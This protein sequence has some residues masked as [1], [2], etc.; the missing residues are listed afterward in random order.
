MSAAGKRTINSIK[1]AQRSGIHLPMPPIGCQSSERCKRGAKMA[2]GNNMNVPDQVAGYKRVGHEPL[3]IGGMGVVWL[4]KEIGLPS[5][6]VAIKFINAAKMQMNK[7]NL[8]REI[9]ILSALPPHQNV[10]AMHAVIEEPFALVMEYVPGNTNLRRIIKG[11]P[12][13]LPIGL[14]AQI[15]EGALEGV[16]HAHEHH[17]LHRDIKPENILIRLTDGQQQITHRCI[18]IVDFGIS[19]IYREGMGASAIDKESGRPLMT[20]MGAYTEAYAA[21]EQINGEPTGAYTDIYQIG[22][23]LHEMLSGSKPFSG[24]TSDII[25]GHCYGQPA[26]IE[27]WDLPRALKAILATAMS[28]NPKERFQNAEEMLRALNDVNDRGDLVDMGQAP[29]AFD[30]GKAYTEE[31]VTIRAG[32]KQKHRPGQGGSIVPNEHIATE[33]GSQGA[34]RPYRPINAV[35]GNKK[36]GLKYAIFAISGMAV[37]AAA[38]PLSNRLFGASKKGKA[39]PAPIN[40]AALGVRGQSDYLGAYTDTL[41]K[42]TSNLSTSSNSGTT[43]LRASQ[44][45]PIASSASEPQKPST[46][47][48]PASR[49]NPA[50]T[51]GIGEAIGGLAGAALH[52]VSAAKDKQDLGSI[53]DKGLGLLGISNQEQITYTPPQP[54]WPKAAPLGPNQPR[55]VV[56]VQVDVGPNGLPSNPKVLGSPPSA[57]YTPAIEYAMKHTFRPRSDSKTNKHTLAAQFDPP[58]IPNN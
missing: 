40:A 22:V 32:I 2:D 10:I 25:A 47:Q 34:N 14:V 35:I 20:L 26:A 9:Q 52:E 37:L 54:P 41:A 5:R 28:K 36:A 50:K 21:P 12:D 15:L 56:R 7:N 18:K 45:P 27:R 30:G 16:A 11:H 13:G 29:E 19:K 33:I 6:D 42:S 23:I 57:F 53:V 31:S 3:G 44:A 51:T 49:D 24:R 39:K 58:A 48:K 17:V 38:L 55:Q 4:Y 8:M 46:A 43:A 1:Q